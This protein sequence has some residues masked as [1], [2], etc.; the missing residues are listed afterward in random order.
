MKENDRRGVLCYVVEQ[1]FF[2]ALVLLPA[3]YNNT[4][5]GVFSG[6]VNETLHLVLATTLA[7]SA[8]LGQRLA[9]A[10]S[11]SP[12]MKQR[13][14]VSFFFVFCGLDVHISAALPI[15]AHFIVKPLKE[16][17]EV[18]NVRLNCIVDCVSLVRNVDS[19]VTPMCIVFF[20]FSLY[21]TTRFLLFR[22]FDCCVH[23][24][25]CNVC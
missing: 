25:L 19:M 24:L 21:R 2:S 16:V 13:R 17:C 11:V 22:P 20:F 10:A 6:N 12:L 3:K 7:T 9:G 1:F 23:I 5:F 15:I 4:L 14:R 18:Q 8:V